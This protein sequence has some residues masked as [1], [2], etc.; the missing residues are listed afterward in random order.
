MVKKIQWTPPM[1]ELLLDLRGKQIPMGEIAG[2]L[3][4]SPTACHNKLQ[5]MGVTKRRPQKH[6]TCPD[7]LSVRSPTSDNRAR[8][9][10][11]PCLCCRAQFSSAS[12][13]NRLCP[14][15]GNQSE[16]PFDIPV[17]IGR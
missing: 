11:R 6:S 5:Y 2:A 1:V 8:A 4:I 14:K 7:H 13:H 12:P 16:S 9:K 3:G 10:R 15:C 17:R